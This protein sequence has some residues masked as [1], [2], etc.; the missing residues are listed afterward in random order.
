MKTLLFATVAIAGLVA[1]VANGYAQDAAAAA[2]ASVSQES[3]G[4]IALDPA[5]EIFVDPGARQQV[6]F[7]P[8]KIVDILCAGHLM[9]ATALPTAT[10]NFTE[11]T[12]TPSAFSCLSRFEEKINVDGSFTLACH[13]KPKP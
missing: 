8:P 3:L 10:V 4:C 6:L 13:S 2:T 11:K 1:G 7:T 5:G 9:P 12:K